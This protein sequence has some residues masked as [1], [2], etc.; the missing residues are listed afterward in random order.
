[1]PIYRVDD[2]SMVP[3]TRLAPGPDLYE[4]EIEDLIW[5]D[6]EAFTGV[7]LFPVRRQ[8]VISAASRPD[9]LALRADGTPVIIEVK[10]DI[11]R[12]QL[13][14][15]LEYA[16][17]ARQTSLDEISRLY[18][19]DTAHEGPDAFFSDWTEFTESTTPVTITSPP[20]LIL[21]ARDFQGATRSAIGFLEEAGVPIT[22]TP[23]T[24]YSDPDGNRVVYIDAEHDLA[25]AAEAGPAKQ[26]VKQHITV[27][28][29]R[30]SVRDLLEAEML[31]P[32]EKVVFTRPRKGQRFEATIEQDGTFTL[33]DG[34]TFDSPSRAA[35]SAADLVSYDGWGAWRVPR[36]ENRLLDELRSQYVAIRSGDSSERNRSLGGTASHG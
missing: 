16:G 15:V 29:E 28:G 32:G 5:S 24:L 17:W 18:K 23:V 21:I 4:Q 11:D 22:I 31:L 1:M 33:W 8:P 10:R 19:I 3:F 30:V 25:T 35:R 6:L 14:Q 13:A 34:R 26:R 27:N 20:A 2:G 36:L 9:I 12:G 7:A